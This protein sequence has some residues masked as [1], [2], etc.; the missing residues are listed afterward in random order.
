MQTATHTHTVQYT[1]IHTYTVKQAYTTYTYNHTYHACTHTH[2]Q[3]H[4]YISTYTHG[5]I[6]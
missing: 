4:S 3:A 2:T 6:Q 5:G 1:V